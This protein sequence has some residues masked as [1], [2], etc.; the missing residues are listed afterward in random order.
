MLSKLFIH[1]KIKNV[2]SKHHK[3][4][5]QFQN[6]KLSKPWY[7]K[8]LLET[9]QFPAVTTEVSKVRVSPRSCTN[10]LCVYSRGWGATLPGAPWHQLPHKASP[11]ATTTAGGC[12]CGSCQWHPCPAVWLPRPSLPKPLWS[13][14]PAVQ[15]PVGPAAALQETGGHSQFPPQ[16][17]QWHFGPRCSKTAFTSL[18][19]PQVHSTGVASSF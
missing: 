3:T 11:E 17:K 16:G 6:M 9:K 19:C 18:R 8:Y 4:C 7:L 1:C 10:H 15:L 14:C 5:M 12:S 13:S 2:V